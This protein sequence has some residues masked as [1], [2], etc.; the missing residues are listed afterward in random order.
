MQKK[1]KAQAAVTFMKTEAKKMLRLLNAA[2]ASNENCT[3]D[4][5][6]CLLLVFFAGAGEPASQ[7][8]NPHFYFIFGFFPENSTSQ[9][10]HS[11]LCTFERKNFT[12]KKVLRKCL[13]VS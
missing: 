1:K 12:K 5:I 2:T 10:A 3:K 9:N 13:K 4:E 7:K 11:M 8:L 6:K